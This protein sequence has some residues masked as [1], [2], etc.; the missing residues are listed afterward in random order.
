MSGT[1]VLL[2][3]ALIV[4]VVNRPHYGDI[5]VEDGRI[6]SLGEAPADFEGDVVECNGRIVMPGL[7]NAHLHPELHILKGIVEELDLHAWEDAE[8]LDAA[9][10]LLASPEGRA[11]QRAA[12]RASI[13][14]CVLTG[15]TCIA[16]YGV[17]D[18][19]DDTSATVLA[20]LGVRGFV[21]IRV[22]IS[23]RSRAADL[24]T[25]SRPRGCTGCTRRRHLRRP[26]SRPRRPRIAGANAW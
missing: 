5:I 18:G 3:N 17:T 10:L 20:E 2:R 15:T 7:I 4:A 12:I 25:R 13:A 22:W 11:I 8:H 19:A 16:T 1:R 6:A 9:L 23:R 26:S 14:D 21:T 24:R